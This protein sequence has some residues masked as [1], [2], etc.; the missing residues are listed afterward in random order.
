G[1]EPDG[2]KG[3]GGIRFGRVEAED[4]E[5]SDH[6]IVN[7]GIEQLGK[8]H[9]KPF[10]LTVG[11]HKPHMP[12]FVPKKYFDLHPL[13]S[14]EL[15]PTKSGDL[16]DVPAAGVKFARPDGDHAKILE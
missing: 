2:S 9:D 3:V 16:S 1:P 12:W 15:P 13:E 5:L 6:R 8:K 4:S 14:I 11:L 7:Y 10:F